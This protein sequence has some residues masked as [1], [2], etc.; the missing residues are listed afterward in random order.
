[1]D[2]AIKI[3]KLGK[4]YR[5]GGMAAPSS[6]L[7]ETL[8]HLAR[9]TATKLNP[10]RLLQGKRAEHRSGKRDALEFWALKDV[11]FEVEEGQILGVIGANGAGKST[12]LK[13]LSR[14]TAPTAGTVRYRGRVASLLE[15]GTGFHRELTGRENIFLNGAIL[16]M[17]RAEIRKR[18]HEIVAFSGVEKFLDTPVKFYSSGMY[19]RLAFSVAAHLEADILMID[20]VLAVGDASFQEKCI[21]KMR[22]V[23]SHAG[24]TVVFVSH[25]MDAVQKLCNRVI[26]LQ[27][28]GVA[29]DGRATEAIERYFG[30]SELQVRKSLKEA[31]NRAGSGEARFLDVELLDGSGVSRCEYQFDYPIRFRTTIEFLKPVD[32]PIVGYNIFSGRNISLVDARS[33]WDGH[34]FGRC[35][36]KRTIEITIPPLQFYPGIYSVQLWVSPSPALPVMDEIPGAFAFRLVSPPH[37]P[38]DREFYDIWGAVHVDSKWKML[39]D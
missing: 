7:R 35:A 5:R 30:A 8:V 31:P 4:K 37:I 29:Y 2:W 13:I 28:G 6:N 33:H 9:Q 1:M 10:L 26:F 16:G 27:K 38:R 12:L 15:V 22:D 14:I 11:S 34:Q 36:G 3:E 25:N 32:N 39:K 17:K 18:L 23:T 24:R 21:G 20:E 19:L